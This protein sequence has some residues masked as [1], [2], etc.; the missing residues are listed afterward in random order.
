MNPK[1]YPFNKIEGY[2]TSQG[3]TLSDLP[4]HT[5]YFT[6]QHESEVMLMGMHICLFT[7]Y[8]YIFSILN[9]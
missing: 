5:D 9:P 8:G 7:L 2:F 6:I 4:G 3:K 1:V